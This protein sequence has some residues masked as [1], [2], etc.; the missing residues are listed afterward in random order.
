V[1]F[2]ELLAQ[3][4]AAFSWARL[5]RALR[6]LELS[7]E[8]VSGHFFTGVPGLQFATPDAVRRLRAGLSERAIWWVNGLDPASP[9]GLDLPGLRGALP[10]R[11]GGSHLVYRGADLL[12]VSRASGREI[13]ID[14]APDD[15]IARELV[16]P[17]RTALTRAFD[18]V[19][20]IDVETINGEAAARS[21]H[22]AAFTDFSVT[23]E[24]SAVRLRRRYGA[25]G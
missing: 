2:R 5:A 25:V 22:L 18:P 9:C 7:G 17:F 21:P 11:V 10:R 15:P 23:R 12:L 19:R 20:A 6:V 1:V 24:G 14:V 3:E 8:I 4:S 13:E 16:G